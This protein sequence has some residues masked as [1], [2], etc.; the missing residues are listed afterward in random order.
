MTREEFARSLLKEVGVRW[1]TKPRLYALVAWMQ[2]EG[3][4][5]AN[6][7]LNTTEKMPLSTTF[8][9][10]GVQNYSSFSEGVMATAKTLNYGAD[11]DSHGYKPIRR[12]LR[13]FLILNRAKKVLEAVE[14]SDWGTGGLALKCL[15]EVKANWDL[16]RG[17]PIVELARRS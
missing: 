2:A 9:S 4:G 10:V 7:P 1:V 14:E 17:L 15:P 16:Y 11:R 13:R 6:N 3:N 12:R 5:G 8:N